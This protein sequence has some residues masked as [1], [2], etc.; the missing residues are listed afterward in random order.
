MALV[1]AMHGNDDNTVLRATARQT[2]KASIDAW[3]AQKM[4]ARAQRNHGHD[5]SIAVARIM[6]GRL[7]FC[8]CDK[9][10]PNA[11]ATGPLRLAFTIV[12]KQCTETQSLIRASHVMWSTGA[13][14]RGSP[15]L[16]WASGHCTMAI[17]GQSL[18]ETCVRGH[19][20]HQVNGT[21]AQPPRQPPRIRCHASA[22]RA[23]GVEA[24]VI[25]K[26]LSSRCP[27]WPRYRATSRSE[28]LDVQSSAP[29]AR[30]L[31]ARP[32]AATSLPR[33]TTTG[34]MAAP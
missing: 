7:R 32:G 23:P 2:L 6:T 8:T 3:H 33:T 20:R 16:V 31:P 14:R 27:R 28:A 24:Q 1:T 30:E 15:R 18:S 9:Q 26:T 5:K 4:M 21:Q 34:P 11:C 10:T 12:R 29:Q 25:A 22:H 13:M 17:C 19:S